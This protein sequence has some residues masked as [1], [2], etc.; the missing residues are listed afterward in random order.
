[1][2][3]FDNAYDYS[4][5]L[6]LREFRSLYIHINKNSKLILCEYIIWGNDENI[7]RMRISKNYYIDATFHTPPLYK[8]LLIFMYKDVLTNLKIPGLYILMN[9]NKEEFY[10]LIFKDII[11]I[12]TLQNKY[13]ISIDTIVTDSEK[14]LINVVKKFFP[15]TR[16][17]S[18]LYHYKQDIILNLRIYGLYKKKIKKNSD[19]VLK[20]LG[21]LPFDY[22]GNITYLE[23][24]L[25]TLINQKPLYENFLNNYFKK[26]KYPYF[27]DK[28]L[29][30]HDLPYD[31]YTNNYLEN[32]NG[33]IKAQL[34]KNR[35]I[36]WV[37]FINFL[38]LESDRI[39]NKLIDNSNKIVKTKEVKEKFNS[40]I[41]L[42]DKNEIN[43]DSVNKDLENIKLSE[44]D[45]NNINQLV[46]NNINYD[47]KLVS[48]TEIN[49]I[50]NSKIGIE[51]IGNSCFANAIIQILIHLSVFLNEFI[52]SFKIEE[53]DEVSISRQFFCIIKDMLLY[54]NE[55][56]NIS[57]FLYVFGY[58]H[59]TYSGYV[60][61]DALEFLRYFL[62]DISL[63]M[64]INKNIPLYKEITFSDET[65]KFICKKEYDNYFLK[66]E[67]SIVTN[68][69]YSQVISSFKCTCKRIFYS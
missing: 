26:N 64:N 51:N 19:F 61:H 2:T 3:V 17:I 69:F 36:N 11:D 63:E 16:R 62:E 50:I 58:K 24:Q 9:G 1:M 52:N 65:S 41:T 31:C 15:T 21:S 10:N 29:D 20:K 33:F 7:A 54:N 45:D 5:R 43:I 46:K 18:C 67:N 35:I 8:Q 60:Q 13:S 34:G 44:T 55:Y 23:E 4:N 37:N 53:T 48:E 27:I 66:R 42:C 68:L 39:I 59:L 30:Y 14:G 40:Q 25:K 49:K 47:I 32:Y 6:I 56:I 12:I 38:K 22:K 57:K 28:S